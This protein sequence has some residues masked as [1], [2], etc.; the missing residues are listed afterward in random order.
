MSNQQVTAAGPPRP[1]MDP[2]SGLRRIKLRPHEMS[3]TITASKDV[4]V[5]AHL[6]IPRIDPAQWRLSVDGL[7][8]EAR[9]LGLD[10]LKAR[11]KSTVEAVHQCCGNPL[12]PKVRTRRVANVRWGGVDLAALLDELDVDPRARFLWSYG[13]DG[14]DFAGTDCDWYVKDMPLE[15]LAAGGVLVAYEMNDASLAAEHGFPVR[16]VVPGYYG[17]NSVKWLW[18]LHVAAH[19]AHTLFTTSLYNDAAD[20][21]DIAAGLPARRPV[22]TIA[23]EIDHR[24]PR[25]RRKHRPGREH[26]D[27]RLGLVVRRRRPRR[28]QRRWRRKLHPRRARGAARLVL[29]ALLAV[30]AAGHARRRAALRS[31]FRSQWNRSAARRRAQCH[32]HRAGLG[33]LIVVP[34]ARA[35]WPASFGEPWSGLPYEATDDKHRKDLGSGVQR[36]RLPFPA[37]CARLF[38]LLLDEGST[39]R[40]ATPK[41]GAGPMVC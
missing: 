35:A 33:A 36:P 2:A 41:P 40:R 27:P 25:A 18:R 4:F 30:M 10:D 11:R 3:D 22:W 5:L 8:G 38:C 37:R 32:S 17:T 29:A 7:V 12:E 39:T 9:T 34:C 21:H 31:R 1:P 16:L 24:G 15:R 20:E 19:R 26:R 14:G 6:G 13:L 23:P 28:G